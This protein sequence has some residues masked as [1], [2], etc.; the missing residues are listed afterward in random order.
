MS[1]HIIRTL[2]RDAETG[3]LA[4]EFLTPAKDIR[5]NGLVI[6]HALLIPPEDRHLAFI[7]EI[8]AAMQG[9]LTTAL[10]LFEEGEPVFAE[11][12]DE[13]PYDNPDER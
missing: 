8:E 7:E 4:F 10:V 5:S 6:N 9:W 11:D 12:S 1:D 3:G 2:S 13:N